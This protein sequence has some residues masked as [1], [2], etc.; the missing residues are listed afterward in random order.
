VKILKTAPDM[1]AQKIIKD[2][3]LTG[4]S[5]QC[6]LSTIDVKFSRQHSGRL[7]NAIDPAIEHSYALCMDNG[8]I[9]MESVL[10]WIDSKNN[11]IAAKDADSK[12]RTALM[13][14]NHRDGA[15]RILNVDA[16]NFFVID[17][18]LTREQ[19]LMLPK[20]LNRR[21]GLRTGD[22]E[23]GI[24]AIFA[25][26]EFGWDLKVAAKK[27]SL[28]EDFIRSALKV[29]E[30]SDILAIKKINTSSV[31]KE[32]LIQLNRLK[33]NQKVLWALASFVIASKCTADEVK[34]FVKEIIE[35]ATGEADQLDKVVQIEKRYGSKSKSTR[36]AWKSPRKTADDNDSVEVARIRQA[37]MK[38]T[39]R[40]EKTL[41]KK[42]AWTEIGFMDAKSVNEIK[43]RWRALLEKWINV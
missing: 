36:K 22:Y 1:T 37:V 14:G 5:Q 34:I 42:H 8:D 32:I 28:S 18:A 13:G 10:I 15:M 20:M 29:Q 26:K 2:Y 23:A 27:F 6:L 41:E 39:S 33:T 9:F 4:H 35:V 30:M 17:Q 25:I 31:P 40:L 11:P 21:H 24:Q 16:A 43:S 3:G 7:E 12:S 38:H 19:L